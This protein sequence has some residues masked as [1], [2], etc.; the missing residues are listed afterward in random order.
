[1]M[2]HDTWR[3]MSS[4]P[5]DLWRNLV[6]GPFHILVISD[7]QGKSL[8]YIVWVTWWLDTF[9]H[10]GTWSHPD[11]RDLGPQTISL[12][13]KW[14]DLNT[15]KFLISHLTLIRWPKSIDPPNQ[16]PIFKEIVQGIHSQQQSHSCLAT[17]HDTLPWH[18]SDVPQLFLL[19]TYKREK[20]YTEIP[21]NP[22]SSDSEK[23]SCDD[24][25][26]CQMFGLPDTCTLHSPTS[27][28]SCGTLLAEWWPSGYLWFQR[29]TYNWTGRM[30]VS[31]DI[32]DATHSNIRCLSCCDSC[33]RGSN[34]KFNSLTY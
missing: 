26:K 27:N 8:H 28:L 31:S 5:L 33:E 18:H 10:V 16:W 19:Y 4:H 11:I 17:G 20:P 34:T 25:I 6:L 32:P 1:M 15:H 13:W 22:V 14:L 24:W 21:P 7:I 3:L 9:S 2:C 12:L 23:T 29:G 30:P